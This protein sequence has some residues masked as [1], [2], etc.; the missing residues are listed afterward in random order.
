V[1]HQ[2]HPVVPMLHPVQ[3]VLDAPVDSGREAPTR[4]VSATP[5]PPRRRGVHIIKGWIGCLRAPRR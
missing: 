3:H 2:T 5:D 1:E 4:D